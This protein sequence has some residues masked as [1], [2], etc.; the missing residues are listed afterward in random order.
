VSSVIS[1]PG[2]NTPLSPLLILALSPLSPEV[3]LVVAGA[4]LPIAGFTQPRGEVG[5]HCLD[6]SK[7]STTFCITRVAHFALKI[8]EEYNIFIRQTI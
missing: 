3:G 2:G 8:G 6:A 1:K 5:V 4:R 7:K